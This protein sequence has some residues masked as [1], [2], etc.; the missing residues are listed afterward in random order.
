MRRLSQRLGG[1]GGRRALWLLLGFVAVEVVYVFIVSAGRFTGWPT[2]LTFLDDQA[3]GFR[4]GHLHFAVEPAAALLAKANP[5]DPAQSL[6]DILS[7]AGGEGEERYGDDAAAEA[8]AGA[9]TEDNAGDV[10]AW[11]DFGPKHFEQLAAQQAKRV[12]PFRGDIRTYVALSGPHL[13]IDLNFRHP[14][15]N[16][17]IYSTLENAPIGQ[18]PV[19]W[20]WMSALQCVNWGYGGSHGCLGLPLTE[21]KWAWDWAETGTPVIVF[22]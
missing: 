8:P 10:P 20:G 22:S 14:Y 7:A 15:D 3:E 17:L 5:F 16:L 6:E 1:L 19:T 9:A 4:G 13:G 21:S 11:S 18:G 12:P 2:Y